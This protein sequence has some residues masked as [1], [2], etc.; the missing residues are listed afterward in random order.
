MTIPF[1]HREINQ[2]VE[3]CRRKGHAP[4]TINRVLD[5]TKA[6]FNR[7]IQWDEPGTISNPVNKIKNLPVNNERERFLNHEEIKHLI[8]I[9]QH[10]APRPVADIILFLLFTGARRTEALN[11]R[12][13]DID[14]QNRTFTILQSKSGKVRRVPLSNNAIEVIK[15][16][17]PT[18]G[19]DYVFANPKTLKPYVHIQNQW[20]RIRELAGINDCRLH[21]LRHTFAS[22][23]VKHHSLYFVQVCLG[24][25]SPMTTKRYAHLSAE[26]QNEAVNDTFKGID[27]SMVA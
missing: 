25:S 21:D 2:L 10:E 27:I 18:I 15:R 19:S 14:L 24:H 1:T 6:I 23:L 11:C 17:T 20:N 26:S 4:A 9:L 3:S 22:E 16:I 7:C 5:I 8:Y 12:W 13:S